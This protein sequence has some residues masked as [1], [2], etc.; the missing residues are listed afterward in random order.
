[1]VG[2][3]DAVGV[4][5]PLALLLGFGVVVVVLACVLAM[6]ALPLAVFEPPCSWLSLHPARPE[7]ASRVKANAA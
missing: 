3:A 4:L 6:A 2:L 5:V 1:V 7:Q